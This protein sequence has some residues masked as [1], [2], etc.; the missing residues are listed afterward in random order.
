MPQAPNDNPN[1]AIGPKI[2]GKSLEG[3]LTGG[4]DE[5][6]SGNGMARPVIPLGFR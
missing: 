2:R 4:V 1:D 5:G 3:K 6:K